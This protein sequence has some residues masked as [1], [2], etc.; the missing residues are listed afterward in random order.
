MAPISCTSKGTRGYL[1]AY[2]NESAALK[3]MALDET[4]IDNE[5]E[6]VVKITDIDA[7][8]VTGGT[9]AATE[10]TGVEWDL[11]GLLPALRAD[12][13]LIEGLVCPGPTGLPRYYAVYVDD[14]DVTDRIGDLVSILETTPVAV[15]GDQPIQWPSGIIAT[16]E[17]G[18]AVEGTGIVETIVAG[19]NITVDDTDPANPI[20]SATGGG[21]AP[22]TTGAAPY[23][24][25][26]VTTP[27]DPAEFRPELFEAI[28]DISAVL[29]TT[30]QTTGYVL[31]VPASPG[32]PAEWAAPPSGGAVDS[33]NAQTGVVVLDQD[34]IAD[35]T[36]A[37]QFTATEKTKL[38]GISG[39]N[40]GDQTLG[41]LGAVP[42]SRTLAGLDLSADRTAS[43]LRTALGLVIGTDVL[44]P[45]GSGA[46]LTG[47]PESAVT[48]LVTDL[49]A[50][51]PL[52][53][54]TFSGTPAAPTA[55]AGTSTTQVATTAF[56][57]AA[58]VRT[59]PTITGL[60]YTLGGAE[61]NSTTGS[62]TASGQLRMHPVWLEA[63]SYDRLGIGVATQ[64]V[65]TWRLGVYPANTTT[66][67]P[68]GETMLLDA[69]TVDPNSATNYV[70]ATI[71]LTIPTTGLYWFAVLC[72]AYTA[73][74]SVAG[75][76]GNAGGTPNLPW[77]GHTAFGTVNSR[78]TWARAKVG[79]A[80]GAIPATCP[81]MNP[82]DQCPQ[83]MARKA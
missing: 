17:E 31:S 62:L 43:A 8:E 83:I 61:S 38:A 16:V 6:L 30:G 13:V 81:T 34:D 25:Y 51:A 46:S 22:D 52:A 69:G 74:P 77:R 68:D 32:D 19:D 56:V 47:I 1:P 53:S 54:P 55:A 14:H 35:G 12:D 63:G 76:H 11:T 75:W 42:T 40:T 72:D 41:S 66:L 36:T 80:T 26:T 82:V 9:Y 7:S 79:V 37:K 2:G 28:T 29:D 39:T 18:D 24:V 50:K 5:D 48:N 20:V 49:A 71:S 15:V 73:T 4:V 64:A 3:V 70:A 58:A 27:G 45:N 60:I 33:V 44:A 21:S 57:T 65:S 59:L 10:L 67:L 23:D 78:G